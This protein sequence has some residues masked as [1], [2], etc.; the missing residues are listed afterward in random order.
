[1]KLP[2][3]ETR[4]W[5]M[6]N[7]LTCIRRQHLLR[8]HTVSRWLSG[9]A[10]ICQHTEQGAH[11]VSWPSPYKPHVLALKKTPGRAKTQLQE[12]VAFLDVL[13]C[14]MPWATPMIRS[15]TW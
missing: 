5:K 1:M 2:K 3:K 15:S 7:F 8:S 12:L 6:K 13:A 4:T 11:Q 9:C 14:V 10:S